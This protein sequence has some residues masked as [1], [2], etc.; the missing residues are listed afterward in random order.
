[1]IRYF[2]KTK[3]II[4]FMEQYSFNYNFKYFAKFIKYR[5]KYYQKK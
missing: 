4:N 1:M 5:H 2:V 3:I